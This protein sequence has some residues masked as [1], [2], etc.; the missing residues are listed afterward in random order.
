[1]RRGSVLTHQGGRP[2]TRAVVRGV[3]STNHAAG[4]SF[5]CTVHTTQGKGEGEG[6][7]GGD[8]K[9]RSRQRN[10]ALVSKR[11]PAESYGGTESWSGTLAGT[12]AISEPRP[13][14]GTGA[15]STKRPR[16]HTGEACMTERNAAILPRT[17]VVRRF[18]T[19]RGWFSSSPLAE[20]RNIVHAHQLFS[21]T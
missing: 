5:D 17:D 20:F 12:G 8:S 9:Q 2:V 19:A 11:G 14:P 21:Y 3:E 7:G 13:K 10:D 1:M 15:G 16:I 4:G 6:G 18:T